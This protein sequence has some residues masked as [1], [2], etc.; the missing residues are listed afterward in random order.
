MLITRM[1]WH[2]L[3]ILNY[4][5]LNNT[6]INKNQILILNIWVFTLQKLIKNTEIY[7]DSYVYKLLIINY[8]NL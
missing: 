7:N 8:I 6:Q 2:D 1:F 4:V 5:I 3:L